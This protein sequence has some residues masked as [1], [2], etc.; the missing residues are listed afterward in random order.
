[1][2]KQRIGIFKFENW[3]LLNLSNS[4]DL[5]PSCFQMEEIMKLEDE[6]REFD[7]VLSE[8]AMELEELK[9]EIEKQKEQLSLFQLKD[10]SKSSDKSPINYEKHSSNA[11]VQTQNSDKQYQS[12][13]SQ[14]YITTHSSTDTQTPSKLQQNSVTQTLFLQK[15]MFTQTHQSLMNQTTQTSQI[16]A[17]MSPKVT[18]HQYEQNR[19]RYIKELKERNLLLV[20]ISQMLDQ[21]LGFRLDPN[22]I[23]NF[24]CLKKNIIEKMKILGG[25]SDQKIILS[26]EKGEWIHK[27]DLLESRINKMSILIDTFKKVDN[28]SEGL[29]K[30]LNAENLKLKETLLKTR[31]IYGLEKQSSI[32]KIND[33]DVAN[34]TLS[35]NVQK[36]YRLLPE[37]KNQLEKLRKGIEIRDRLLDGVVKRLEV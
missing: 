32:T 29:T 7:V 26:K 27:C 23:K 4:L 5:I 18:K 25:V 13:D 11:G 35:Q 15:Q 6:R 12:T 16:T 37:Y 3:E 22:L 19:L 2:V 30:R 28:N 1:M 10:N 36:L 31:D 33:L 17:A 24:D 21:K 9:D 8:A 34:K 14:T 20:R